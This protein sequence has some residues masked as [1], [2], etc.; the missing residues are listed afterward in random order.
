[1]IIRTTILNNLLYTYDCV[2]LCNL[3]A[4]RLLFIPHQVNYSFQD[5]F[6]VISRVVLLLVIIYE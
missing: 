5:P 3:Y 4:G 2:I 1:M 6:I